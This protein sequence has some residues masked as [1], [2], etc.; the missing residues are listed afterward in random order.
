MAGSID[1]FVYKSDNGLTY[2]FRGDVSNMFAVGASPGLDSTAQSAGRYLQV[3][4]K[5]PIEM[6]YGLFVSRD[7]P[8]RVKRVVIPDPESGAWQSQVVFTF[9]GDVYDCTSKVG[10][11]RRFLPFIDTG[12]TEGGDDDD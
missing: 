12:I 8:N 10:E 9:E 1:V 6:R 7:D 11:H 4:G 3:S 2:N 5:V